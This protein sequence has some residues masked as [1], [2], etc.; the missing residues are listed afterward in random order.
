MLASTERRSWKENTAS[1]IASGTQNTL[2]TLSPPEP[3]FAIDYVLVANSTNFTFRSTNTYYV[4]GAFL[5]GGTVTFEPATVIKYA[6]TNFSEIR[7]DYTATNIVWLGEPYRPI[8]CTARDDNSVGATLPGST[9]NPTNTYA[10]V[11]LYFDRT[12]NNGVSIRDLRVSYAHLALKLMYGQSKHLIR[13]AQFVRCNNGVSGYSQAIEMQ[14]ILMDRV[15]TNFYDLPYAPVN[16]YFGTYDTGNQI[17][18]NAM[19][20]GVTNYAVICTGITNTSNVTFFGPQ[21]VASNSG[22]FESSAAGNHYLQINSPFLQF[23]NT[24]YGIAP[25]NLTGDAAASFLTYRPPAVLSGALSGQVTFSAGGTTNPPSASPSYQTPGYRYWRLDLVVSNVTIN[26]GGTLNINGQCR[27]VGLVGTAVLNAG[28]GSLNITGTPTDHIRLLRV[29]AV[30]E[31]PTFG[32]LSGSSFKL[33]SGNQVNAALRFADVEFIPSETYTRRQLIDSSTPVDGLVTFKDCLLRAVNLEPYYS[34]Y[35]SGFTLVLNNN[36]L[37]W[38]RVS[39]GQAPS[40]GSPPFHFQFYNNLFRQNSFSGG[41]RGSAYGNWNVRDNF[42]ETSSMSYSAVYPATFPSSN[43]GFYQSTALPGSGNKTVTALDW[44]PGPLGSYYYPSAGTSGSL[45]NLLNF[46]SRTA[47]SAGLAQ[48]TCITDIQNVTNGTPP[49]NWIEQ[50]QQKDSGTVDIGFHYTAVSKVVGGTTSLAPAYRRPVSNDGWFPSDSDYTVGSGGD[51]LSD[52][53]EDVNGNGIPDGSETNWATWD[54]D[55]DYFS[56]SLEPTMGTSPIDYDTDNDGTMDSEEYWNGTDP[57][58]AGD[59]PPRTLE[60]FRMDNSSFESVGGVSP[61]VNTALLR[62]SFDGMAASFT[63]SGERLVYPVSVGTGTNAHSIIQFKTGSVRFTYMPDVFAS[64]QTNQQPVRLLECGSWRLSLQPT[65]GFVA[66]ESPSTNGSVKTNFTLNMGPITGLSARLTWEITLSYSTYSSAIRINSTGT[67]GSG[68]E[69]EPSASEK[70]AGWCVGNGIGATNHCGGRI[71]KLE[72]FNTAI[73]LANAGRPTSVIFDDAVRRAQLLSASVVS[74]GIRLE[75]NR[76]WEG[77]WQTNSSL[78]SIGRRTAGE[79]GAFS[80]VA[81][82]VRTN[83]WI[84]T[85]AVLGRY[86]EYR[87]NRHSTIPVYDHPTITVGRN[88]VAMDRRGRALILVDNTVSNSIATELEAYKADLI[89]DGWIVTTTNAPRHMDPA[90]PNP[91]TGTNWYSYTNQVSSAMTTNRVNAT[92]L[93][94]YITNWHNLSPNDTNVIVIVG[95]VTVPY[96][97]S[98]AEDGHPEH[99]GAWPADSWYGD[100][101]GA[102]LD[103]QLLLPDGMTNS[104][105]TLVGFVPIAVNYPNDGRWNQNTLPLEPDGSPGRLELA[106][107]R[108]DFRMLEDFIQGAEEISNVRDDTEIRLIR[109]YFNKTAGFRR[110]QLLHKEDFVAFF[111]DSSF[112]QTAK[113]VLRVQKRAWNT[114]IMNPDRYQEDLF[115]SGPKNLM[116]FI[117]NYGDYD[118]IGVNQ[119]SYQHRVLDIAGGLPGNTPRGLFQLFRGSYFGEWL[120]GTSDKQGRSLLRAV[121]AIPDASLTVTWIDNAV[122]G[123]WRPDR[124]FAGAHYGTALQ[125][126]FAANAGVSC[127]TTFILGDPLLRAHPLAPITSLANS[128]NGTNVTLSWAVNTN[129]TAGYRILRATSTNSASWQVLA[130]VSATSTNWTHTATNPSTNVYLVKAQALKTTGSGSYTN[131]SLGT[132]SQPVMIP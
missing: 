8:Y 30:N 20:G 34:G 22:A 32:T 17:A 51:A 77:D 47:A 36:I 99:R 59:Y 21:P 64:A 39:V 73:L 128:K 79:T 93:K 13:H 92:A 85:A 108:I 29:A 46:G 117:G 78:Y 76:G 80:T 132:F 54:S 87:V 97:G 14:N 131:T 82:G 63:N 121:L 67:S 112:L 114:E 95:H 65:N 101:T 125:D 50:W 81:S 116:G 4:S 110:A 11:A 105:G 3:G 94:S 119:G 62:E 88:G 70:N 55:G 33:F 103:D 12:Y 45:T 15:K 56:D 123:T 1:I 23:T 31:D 120:N 52:F 104:D 122:W 42:F 61:V 35:S 41:Y 100:L 10:E 89:A 6:S 24:W 130:E 66:F 84:D 124:F 98:I 83:A 9:G 74:N 27:R 118:R 38:S 72:T 71:D 48:F 115:F 109:Q 57:L 18:F 107:G 25:T 91:W 7:V 60:S 68:V 44:V 106:V 37:E 127:R 111:K 113:T 5:L 43:N 19:S 129:A 16:V 58:I 26:G 69:A 2:A 86:Y 49:S 90:Y 40:G 53:V 28:G 75:F 102:W 96:S 126:S